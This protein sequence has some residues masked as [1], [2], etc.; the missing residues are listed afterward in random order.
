ML[1]LCDVPVCR[2]YLFLLLDFPLLPPV[3]REGIIPISL[4]PLLPLYDVYPN[5]AP[6]SLSLSPSFLLSE[7]Y[8]SNC[9][10]F[11]SQ[12]R[13][14]ARQAA[15]THTSVFWQIHFSISFSIE[16]WEEEEE[17]TNGGLPCCL[18]SIG[19]IVYFGLTAAAKWAGIRRIF[20]KLHIA[21]SVVTSLNSCPRE[22][23]LAFSVYRPFFF[24]FPGSVPFLLRGVS[25]VVFV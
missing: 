5:C 10:I 23:L 25:F 20:S 2:R 12:A 3:H 14:A 19:P 11:L 17:R 6:D 24:F 13:P 16:G 15:H 7:E 22:S 21:M 1:L 4:S 9:S 18:L 8:K